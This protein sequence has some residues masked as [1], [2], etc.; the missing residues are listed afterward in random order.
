MFDVDNE[1]NFVFLIQMSVDGVELEAC[2][3]GLRRIYTLKLGDFNDII[4]SLQYCIVSL[5]A[6]TTTQA[7]R[8][9]VKVLIKLQG[10]LKL[11]DF[12]CMLEICNMFLW[13]LKV[14]YA[15]LI[16]IP[17]EDI[18]MEQK[19]RR[20]REAG[21]TSWD[22]ILGNPQIVCSFLSHIWLSWVVT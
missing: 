14:G 11:I 17:M 6:Y 3:W 2:Y 4:T 18:F 12:V 21:V 15:T 1:D 13:T 22:V 16:L 5:K 10:F 19:R 9:V 20:Y 7:L 8:G